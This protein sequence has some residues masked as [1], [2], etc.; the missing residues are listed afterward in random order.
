MGNSDDINGNTRVCC[1]VPTLIS[2]KFGQE[3]SSMVKHKM[4]YFSRHHSSVLRKLDSHEEAIEN[5]P[6]YVLFACLAV[7]LLRSVA[8]V[9]GC[10]TPFNAK[11]CYSQ[12][13]KHQIQYQ[14]EGVGQV[15]KMKPL[16]CCCTRNYRGQRDGM[17]SAASKPADN[18]SISIFQQVVDHFAQSPTFFNQRYSVDDTFY[19]PG[20]PAICMEP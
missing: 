3:L 11:K 15:T 1:K 19:V 6:S 14:L 4:H 5:V 20:G 18:R 2:R 8:G 7:Y 13:V 16:W 12:Q 9:A 10:Y 17:S